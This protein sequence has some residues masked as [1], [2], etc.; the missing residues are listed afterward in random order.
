MHDILEPQRPEELTRSER[1]AA[2][3]YLMCWK[4]K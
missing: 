4:E 3:A 1:A 2:L